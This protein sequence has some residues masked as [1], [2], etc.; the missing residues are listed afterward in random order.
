M[1]LLAQLF[2]GS[3]NKSF[4]IL[5]FWYLKHSLRNSKSTIISQLLRNTPS[6][7]NGIAE[8]WSLKC[9]AVM[10]GKQMSM[11]QKDYNFSKQQELMQ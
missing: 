2:T 7:Q 4:C 1:Y 9:N 5:F 8:N 11:F 10:L 6:S 3:K